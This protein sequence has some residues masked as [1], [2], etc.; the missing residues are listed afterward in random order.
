[1]VFGA[2]WLV[3]DWVSRRAEKQELENNFEHNGCTPVN[4]HNCTSFKDFRI[5][6]AAHRRHRCATFFPVDQAR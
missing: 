5:N 3:A 1:V 2:A 6:T 4:A